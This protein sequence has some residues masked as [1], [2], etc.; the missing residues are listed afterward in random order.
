MIFSFLPVKSFQNV[1]GKV[2]KYGSKKPGRVHPKKR[3]DCTKF[4]IEDI[5]FVA[6]EA[7]KEN[8]IK[9]AGKIT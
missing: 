2:R 5:D 4:L 7:T 8:E 6:G 3:G 1:L 9:K